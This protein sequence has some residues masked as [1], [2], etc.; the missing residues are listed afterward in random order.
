MSS[1]NSSNTSKELESRTTVRELVTLNESNQLFVALLISVALA[2]LGIW[3]AWSYSGSRGL[4]DIDRVEPQKLNLLIDVNTASEEELMML[5]IV[6]ET[7]AER[8]IRERENG[9]FKSSADFLKRVKG[10]GDKKFETMK[11]YLTGWEQSA[12]K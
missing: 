2:I 12:E 6:A 4:V 11:Q 5:P 10:L 9:L 3:Y 7:T 8:I 1:P